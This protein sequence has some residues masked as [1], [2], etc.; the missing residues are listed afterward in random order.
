MAI[1]KFSWSL[2][3]RCLAHDMLYC[4][5]HDILYCHGNESLFKLCYWRPSHL[6]RDV[7]NLIRFTG[8]D[9]NEKIL[10]QRN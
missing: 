6:T 2:I 9:R 7:W 5:A 1:G 4:P 10:K 3:N 8:Y